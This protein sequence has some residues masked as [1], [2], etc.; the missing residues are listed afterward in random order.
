MEQFSMTSTFYSCAG[1][2]S[3]K[4]WSAIREMAANAES[5]TSTG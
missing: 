4:P 5:G 1:A 3:Q 2:Q